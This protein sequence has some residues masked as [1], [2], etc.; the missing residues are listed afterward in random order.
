MLITKFLAKHPYLEFCAI[1]HSPK[2][3]FTFIICPMYIAC[4]S[5]LP[6]YFLMILMSMGKS[7][8]C[9]HVPVPK[10]QFKTDKRP[11]E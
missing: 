10:S 6:F 2:E 8:Y 3:I 5:L 4:H 11:L 9:V 7:G 1:E